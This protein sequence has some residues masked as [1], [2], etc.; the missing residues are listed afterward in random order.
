LTPRVLANRIWHYHFG[1]GLVDTPGDFGYMGGRPTHPALLDW[2][3]RRLVEG[4]WQFKSMNR[5]IVT[6]QAY[7]QSAAY[8]ED[9]ARVDGDSRLLWRYPPRRLSGEELRDTML[10][11]AGKLEGPRGGP[12]FRLYQYVQDNVAAYLPLDRH[13]PETYR[14]AVYHQNARASRVDV[15]TDFDCPDSAFS[16]PRR[17]L[18]TTPM[19]AL[20]LL[21]HSFTSDMA[22][23]LAE[24]LIRE[25][26]PEA[27]AQVDRAFALAYGRAPAPDERMDAAAFIGKQGLKTFARVILNTNELIYLH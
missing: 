17:A 3:A 23:F 5:L 21:N 14:R 18:T 2:L 15:L 20:T 7:R 25:A 13:G 24:R 22:A 27:G 8:R 12:G 1:T 26:G 19:Q 10:A 16:A 4:G 9:A 11:L 6:S